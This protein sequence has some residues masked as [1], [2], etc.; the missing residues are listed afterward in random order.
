MKSLPP[1]PGS[2]SSVT[3]SPDRVGAIPA[4]KYNFAMLSLRAV[5][6]MSCSRPVSEDHQAL[7]FGRAGVWAGSR[8]QQEEGLHDVPEGVGWALNVTSVTAQPA[9]DCDWLLVR[10]GYIIGNRASCGHRQVR[11]RPSWGQGP[12]GRW[13]VNP[14]ATFTSWDRNPRSP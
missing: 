9:C 8:C 5:R 10:R 11:S 4:G 6:F 13:Q 14:T 3:G 7:Y 1:G 2:P 12:S